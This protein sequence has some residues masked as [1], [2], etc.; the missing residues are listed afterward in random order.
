MPILENQKRPLLVFHHRAMV[1]DDADPLFRIAAV[2][3]ENA[4]DLAARLPF[5]NPDD[6]ILVKLREASRLQNIRQDIRGDLGTP[7]V[8]A[9]HALWSEI[10]ADKGHQERHGEGGIEKGHEKP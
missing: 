4:E 9:P 2:V 3:D 1:G 7:T 8:G 6:E 10:K 5:P